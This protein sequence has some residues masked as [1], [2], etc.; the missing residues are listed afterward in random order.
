M[1]QH[2]TNKWVDSF[3]K[4]A[5]IGESAT[6]LILIHIGTLDIILLVIIA[7]QTIENLNKCK[8]FSCLNCL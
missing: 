2:E 4:G 6:F 7:T 1:L 3:C 8:T 5:F